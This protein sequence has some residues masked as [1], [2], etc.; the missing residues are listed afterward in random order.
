MTSAERAP[1]NRDRIAQA[2]LGLVGREGLTALTMRRLGAELGVEAMSLY[3]HVTNKGDLLDAIVERVYAEVQLP[4]ADLPWREQARGVFRGFRQVGV[5]HPEAFALLTQRAAP[6]VESL[7]VLS[8]VF[9][10]YRIAG[11]DDLQAWRAFQVSA[12]YVVGFVA[13]QHGR[14]A[15]TAAPNGI[16]LSDLATD[17][18]DVALFGRMSGRGGDDDFD[19]GVEL[20]LSGFESL[21]HPVPPR[22]SEQ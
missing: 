10:V 18:P 17:D 9:A 3:N 20:L 15:E 14:M 1:L 13:T 21:L 19:T 7:R 8:R 5:E 16:D 11:F 2:A 4:A 6:S 22:V 12:S